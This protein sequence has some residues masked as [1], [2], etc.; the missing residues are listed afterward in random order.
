[1]VS[2]GFVAT[3]WN[4]RFTC[5][6]WCSCNITMSALVRLCPPVLVVFHA[7]F[8]FVSFGCETTSLDL[9]IFTP[10]EYMILATITANCV[11]LALEQHLPGED[12]TPMAKRLVR[13]RSL[14]FGRVL[15]VDAW[16]GGDQM[17]RSWGVYGNLIFFL[18][19]AHCKELLK[20]LRGFF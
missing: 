3:E 2:W 16:G 17:W 18:T 10:F 7:R 5:Q 4:E 8:V 13:A 11:V 15:L 6:T 12:K 19:E 1:M 14:F 20:Q 9:V